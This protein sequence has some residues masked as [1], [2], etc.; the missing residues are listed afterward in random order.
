MEYVVEVLN[1]AGDIIYVVKLERDG[2][3][4]WSIPTPAAYE[5]ATK[6]KVKSRA[7]KIASLAANALLVQGKD[8]GSVQVSPYFG[9][10][11]TGT[12]SSVTGPKADRIR[13]N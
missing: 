11:V 2:R 9:G 8:F 12:K 3:V 13:R 1:G 5:Y 10:I 6:F 7:K 4:S